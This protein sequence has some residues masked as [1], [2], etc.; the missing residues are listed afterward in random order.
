MD[1]NRFAEI[2]ND[3][4]AKYKS[5]IE[6]TDELYISKFIEKKCIE[7]EIEKNK[8]NL[9]KCVLTKCTTLAKYNIESEEYKNNS[10]EISRLEREGKVY[11]C[12]TLNVF[13][14]HLKLKYAFQNSVPEY[15]HEIVSELTQSLANV[16]IFENNDYINRTLLENAVILYILDK[17]ILVKDFEAQELINAG[18]RLSKRYSL[19]FEIKNADIIFEETEHKTIHKFLLDKIS[20][21]GGIDFLFKLYSQEISK[22]F[23]P[24]LN[25]YLI[26][27]NK[28]QYLQKKPIARIPFNYLIQISFKCLCIKNMLLTEH[29]KNQLYNEVIEISKDYLTC[30]N[31]QNHTIFGDIFREIKDIP[32]E[33]HKN[34]LFDRIHTP[35]QYN[36]DFVYRMLEVIANGFKTEVIFDY[37]VK[38]YLKF[39]KTILDRKDVCVCYTIEDIARTTGI[40]KSTIIKILADTSEDYNNINTEFYD[41]F[42]KTNYIEKP[43]I[44]LKNGTFFLFCPH[45]NGISFY[46]V[47]Y[48]KLSAIPTIISNKI[49]KLVEK[50]I[51]NILDIKNIAYHC[52]K[53]KNPDGTGS[54]CDIV[55]ENNK[56]I[57]FLEIKNRPLSKTLEFGEDVE[58]LKTLSEG[59]VYA[60]K[61]CFSHALYL[62]K[63]GKL[64]LINEDDGSKYSLLQSDRQIICVSVCLHEYLF[65]TDKTFSSYLLESLLFIEYHAVD[66]NEEAYAK[67]LND[68]GNKLKKIIEEYHGKD[69]PQSRE[70]FFDSLFRSANQIY[71]IV[72]KSND[73]NSFID[74]LTQPI[75]VMDGSGDIYSQLRKC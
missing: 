74:L 68:I 27:K 19:K 72:M 10:I 7:Y 53:Y 44:K 52:G 58:T 60:Q 30:L 6:A 67:K 73:T 70:V 12:G 9:T 18:K 25:R 69:I 71:T 35:L 75:Y 23:E 22:T 24:K 17:P 8:T 3:I 61:Q 46:H 62:K 63:F 31:L 47:F 48:K 36:P 40:N 2:L 66:P 32:Y 65:L 34:I 42:S 54:D 16:W 28:V 43:F 37:S 5:Y 21:I 29:G 33:L 1:L 20:A 45:F 55:I 56:K 49:G 41:I 4:I 14:T 13:S 39:C 11:R 26:Q 15:A 64:E 51:R 57:I 38:T 50:V 59:M